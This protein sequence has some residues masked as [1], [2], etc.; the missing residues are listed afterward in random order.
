MGVSGAELEA[1]RGAAPGLPA[2][3]VTPAVMLG[4]GTVIYHDRK[5]RDKEVCLSLNRVNADFHISTKEC[6]PHH[7]RMP[8]V[9]DMFP[10]LWE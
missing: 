10:P 1:L 7:V 4:G 5:Q 3:P 8:A 9:T 6:R 2:R